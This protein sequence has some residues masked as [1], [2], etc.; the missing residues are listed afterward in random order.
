MKC[1]GLLV[2]LVASLMTG[3]ASLRPA[4]PHSPNAADATAFSLR[5][6]LALR[7]QDRYLS[8]GI[9]WQHSAAR[10][11]ML[12]LSPLGQGVMQITRDAEGAS[13]RTAD[14]KS[15][16]AP[17]AEEL[18]FAVTGWRIPVSGL[19][20]WIRGVPRDDALAAPARGEQRDAS[21]RLSKFAQ[22]DWTIEYQAYFDAPDDKLPRRVLLT[23]SEFELKLVIDAWEKAL[24]PPALPAADK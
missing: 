4:P 16:N 13:L 3:C 19:A 10:D 8:G 9:Q 2:A 5:G 24:T 23:H 6:R 18:A 12:L 1:R 14:D 22:D 21:G 15:F 7:E 20:A 17:D 11:D